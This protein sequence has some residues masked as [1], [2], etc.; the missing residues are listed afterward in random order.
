MQASKNKKQYMIDRGH[1]VLLHLPKQGGVEEQDA[2]TMQTLDYLNIIM[3][4]MRKPSG[5]R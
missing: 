5:F 1:F 3:S 4:E 2:L